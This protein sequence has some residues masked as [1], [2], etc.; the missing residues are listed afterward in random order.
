MDFVRHI[1]FT[2]RER[3]R[4]VELVAWM[5][6][7]LSHTTTNVL[8]CTI[9]LPLFGG[10]ATSLPRRS[11]LLHD[12]VTQVF[13]RSLQYGIVVM[14]FVDVFVYA[15]DH[16]RRNIENPGNFGDCMKGR[17]R[18]MTAITPGYAH[19]YQVTCLTRDTPA[20]QNQ[21]FRLPSANA[22][23]PHLP[24]VRTTTTRKMQ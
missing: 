11:H 10:H 5:N 6:P 3:H 13:Q 23:Y 12:L 17:I 16:H 24:C 19:A 20:V 9:C 7:T 22:R 8:S 2:L 14:G 21:R 4:C 1:D 18:F 15:H